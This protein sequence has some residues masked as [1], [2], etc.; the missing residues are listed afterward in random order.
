[1]A[2]TKDGSRCRCD[3]ALCTAQKI[4]SQRYKSVDAAILAKAAQEVMQMKK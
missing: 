2:N 1:M 4:F 3:E